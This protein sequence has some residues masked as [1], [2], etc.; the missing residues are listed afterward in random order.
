[1]SG[2]AVPFREFSN[3]FWRL[4]RPVV[5]AEPQEFFGLDGK[6]EPFRSSGGIAAKIATKWAKF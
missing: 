5:E 2:K 1:M 3:S 4:R 6:A